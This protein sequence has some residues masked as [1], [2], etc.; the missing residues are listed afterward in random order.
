M[1]TEPQPPFDPNAPLP[2]LP[3][4]WAS[5]PTPDLRPGPPYH[6]TE[7][8]AAEPAVARRIVARLSAPGGGAADLADAIRATLSAG[9]LVVVTGCGTS[10][11]AALGAVDILR[12]AAEAAG[13]DGTRIRSEQA[14]ELSLE[15]PARGLVIG[16]SHEGGTGATIA[17]MAA[18]RTAGARTAVLTASRHSPAAG[19]ADI[20]VETEEVDQ[21]WC[22]TV[23][24]VSALVAAAAT[25]AALSGRGLD[26][27][28]VAGL[29]AAGT[30]GEAFAETIAAQLADAAHLIVIASGADRTAGRELV[31]KIEEAAWL[32]SAYR[33]LETFLHG[34]L[35]ANGP[36]TG[37]VLVLV[38]RAGRSAR[39]AR[40][41]GA[42]AA[43]R[44]VGSRTAAILAADLDAD[45]D[46]ALTPAGRLLVTDTPDLP[47]PVAAL[48][49]SATPL[50]LLTERIARARGTNPDLIRRD[51]PV[52]L[53]AADAAE[54]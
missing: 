25:G 23:A 12:E 15:A 7:M 16:V 10:E 19:V 30:R 45:L 33:D 31:L 4:P 20:V 42:L 14:F 5:A 49:G 41:R 39:L 6:M 50:Q 37:L 11:H 40:A 27:E 21:S 18:A 3:D 48:L 36:D 47:S 46:P 44:V 2:G 28:A 32:P 53:A 13:L 22:H 34:H 35:P 1:T 17:A 29:L 9:D 51:D 26:G 54:G 52:Y 43:A 24:Y 8:I 38:D